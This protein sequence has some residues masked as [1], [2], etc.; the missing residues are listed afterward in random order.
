MEEIPP[1][2]QTQ[3]EDRNGHEHEEFST[4]VV[5]E[6]KSS[7]DPACVE[8]FLSKVDASR[9]NDGAEM[10]AQIAADEEGKDT[11]VHISASTNR[12]LAAAELMELRK[13]CID[14]TL[15]EFSLAE[16]EHYKGSGDL[17]TFLTTAEKQRIVC[18]EIENIRAT[19][20]DTQI[21]GYESK[22]K[23]LYPGES[24]VGR[25][26]H[27]GLIVQL[28]PLHEE[29]E[30]KSLTEE[31]FGSWRT[32]LHVRQPVE[33]VRKY[34]G[35]TYAMYFAF[36]GHYTKALIPPSMI[37]IFYIIFTLDGVFKQT[38]F[39]VFNLI[40][41]TLF[42]EM[43]KR[44]SAEHAY[45]WGTLNTKLTEEPRAAFHGRMGVNLIT[46]KPE[47]KY[48]KK[49]RLLKFYGVSLPSMIA[50]LLFCFFMMM[51]YFWFQDF[52]EAI[53]QK[54]PSTA[55]S[56]LNLM[57]SVVYAVM[58]G[59]ANAVYRPLAVMLNEWENHR[60]QS[61]YDNHLIVK[62]LLFYSANC[63]MSL[64]WIAFVRQN[65]EEL[66][67][68]LMTLL[69]IQQLIGQ[70]RE[71]LIPFLTIKYGEELK[72]TVQAGL[73]GIK[74][75]NPMRLGK[76]LLSSETGHQA[77]IERKMAPSEGVLDEY[78]EIFLQ[79]GY[80]FLFSSVFPSAAIWAFINNMMEIRTD[81]LKMCKLF[82]RPF[83]QPAAGIGAW[84]LAFELMGVL[85]V[86]TNCALLGL[87]PFA[88]ALVPTVGPVK[89]V[90]IIVAVEH[91]V[92]FFKSTLDF[93]IPDVPK[94]VQIAVAKQEYQSK[95]AWRKQKSEE[96]RKLLKS[97]GRKILKVDV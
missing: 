14:G 54:D 51:V 18:H 59:V 38:F 76:K 3:D 5:V 46:G 74:R 16:V 15:R 47:P 7:I 36:L 78:L 81:A 97:R 26:V 25:M 84:Q 48:S 24:I 69:I 39:C 49:K 30:L 12:L 4:L 6:F 31:W 11:V 60:L 92:M 65:M 75:L 37:S 34:F 87:S 56:I 29:E 72:K 80:V 67:M 32:L 62:L 83:P 53:Y 9:S 27:D 95:Q 79:F 20:A 66:R 91:A 77:D 44:N 10:Q 82:Q 94:W 58:I 8:W 22:L 63:F 90:L 86:I 42:L 93:L 28:F 57:P 73:G 50:G 96:L 68:T 21:P 61:S 35:E 1:P 13:P 19:E 55:N 17:D 70:V 71:S 2:N 88:Q 64:F 52:T 43:W 85:A 33:K 41:V 45:T 23:G 40:W 89:L